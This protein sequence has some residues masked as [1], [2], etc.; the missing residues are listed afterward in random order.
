MKTNLLHLIFIDIDL[1]E[2]GFLFFRFYGHMDDA[3]R[4]QPVQRN[5]VYI[6]EC[7]YQCA[8]SCPDRVVDILEACGALDLSSSLSRD[9]KFISE[10][11]VFLF[12]QFYF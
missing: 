5:K 12:L 4:I 1:R 7:A 2:T 3:S 6:L 10:L 9:V 11:P 8:R